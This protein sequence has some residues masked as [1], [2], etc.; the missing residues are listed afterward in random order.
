MYNHDDAQVR[1]ISRFISR[2]EG[3][4]DSSNLVLHP[5][6]VFRIKAGCN[7]DNFKIIFKGDRSD[8][9]KLFEQAN[10]QGYARFNMSYMKLYGYEGV[11]IEA[12]Y[13]KSSF[14]IFSPDTPDKLIGNTRDY[15]FAGKKLF[16]PSQADS[17][18]VYN[19]DD[20]SWGPDDCSI[21]NSVSYRYWLQINNQTIKAN[22]QLLR[23]EM[24]KVFKVYEKTHFAEAKAQVLI[25]F[26]TI[27]IDTDTQAMIDIDG[28]R[29]VLELC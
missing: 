16:A 21:P 23:V 27:L 17:L 19:T 3:L 22:Y 20:K 6:T 1:V 13:E 10:L 14:C 25:D 9:Y 26:P 8:L 24:P 12:Q 11:A 15:V 2:I 29:Y 28:Y 7:L 4:T 5:D 18:L